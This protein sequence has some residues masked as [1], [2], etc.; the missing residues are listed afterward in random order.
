MT[1]IELP[2]IRRRVGLILLL[3]LV[4]LVL[5]SVLV[6]VIISQVRERI[7]QATGGMS[8]HVPTPGSSAV[9][10]TEDEQEKDDEA[11][12]LPTIADYLATPQDI[13]ERVRRSVTDPPVI[14]SLAIERAS[15]EVYPADGQRYTISPNGKALRRGGARTVPESTFDL[16]PIDLSILPGLLDSVK[17]THGVSPSRAVLEAQ[18]GT[19]RWQ[20]FVRKDGKGHTLRFEI[21]GTPVED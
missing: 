13:A 2:D 7:D 9:D 5:V 3:T 12:P 1:V 17:Q 4:P 21:D 14:R 11:P 10:S 16:S 18:T 15:V 20:M 8:I 6:F 19:P